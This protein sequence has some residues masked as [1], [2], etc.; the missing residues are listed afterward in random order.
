ML[1]W[2]GTVAAFYTY[3]IE[4]DMEV[5][6]SRLQQAVKYHWILNSGCDNDIV[7]EASSFV[8]SFECECATCDDTSDCE[9]FTIE[10]VV[11][12]PLTFFTITAV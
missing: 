7:C 10:N 8:S 5:F 3:G 6:K 12:N 1:L 11:D 9:N 4:C 2:G